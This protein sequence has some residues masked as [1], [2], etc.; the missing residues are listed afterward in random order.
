MSSTQ[1]ARPAL[2]Q[3]CDRFFVIFE[4]F[5]TIS[6]F[7]TQI[8]RFFSCKFSDLKVWGFQRLEGLQMG[9]HCETLPLHRNSVFAAQTRQQ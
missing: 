3:A 9:Q 7:E 1:G 6:R 4:H 5:C 2:S 8:S